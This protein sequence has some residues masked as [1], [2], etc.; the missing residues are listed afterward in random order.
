MGFCLDIWYH[1]VI[2]KKFGI[3]GLHKKLSGE[4][5]SCELSISVASHE[6]E[7]K[8]LLI[9]SEVVHHDAQ[10][11][12]KIVGNNKDIIRFCKCI[13]CDHCLMKHEK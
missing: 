4:I 11:P 6:A 7:T 12:L 2:S 3:G 1:W 5:D 10:P 13:L 8:L 9:V